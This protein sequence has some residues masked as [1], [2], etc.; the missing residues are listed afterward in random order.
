[1]HRFTR[2]AILPATISCL[3]LLG[4]CA[5][6]GTAKKPAEPSAAK[7][8]VPAEKSAQPAAKPSAPAAKPASAAAPAGATE[9][10]K[11]EIDVPRDPYIDLAVPRQQPAPKTEA[12]KTEPPKTEAPK[13][14]PPTPAQGQ[15]AG[16]VKPPPLMLQAD[17]VAILERAREKLAEVR[18]LD[19][20]T[21]T[22]ASENVDASTIPGL[23]LRHRVQLRFQYSDA[24]SLPF[25]RI[26]RINATAQGIQLGPTVAYNGKSAI[27]ID[28]RERSYFDSG[29]NWARVIGPVIPAIP[30]WFLRERM[31]AARKAKGAQPSGSG[32]LEPELIGAR[33]LGQEEL[34]G[35]PCDIVE[36]YF[37]RNVVTFT[38]AGAAPQ[39]VDEQRYTETTHFA[40]TD[41]M[42]RKIVRRDF[43]SPGSG[44]NTGG[45]VTMLYSQMVVNPGFEPEYFAV[46]PPAGYTRKDT[47]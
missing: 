47:P 10:P 32:A 21:L 35:Q 12:P 6:S 43:P 38:E 33:V 40:K 4:G 16:D 22:E 46:E 20:I 7:P 27:V 30:Q 9:A 36:L 3:A 26:T 13:K 25:L 28:D 41:G 34:D 39:V 37:S 5:S 2:S 15:Q 23:G 19:C 31:T 8:A 17:A 18:T 42:P 11:Y 14:E 24:V 45:T 29:R 1:M 44:G